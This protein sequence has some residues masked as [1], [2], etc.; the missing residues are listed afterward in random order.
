MDKCITNRL[1]FRSKS[2]SASEVVVGNLTRR[3][4]KLI[5]E[6]HAAARQEGKG[7]GAAQQQ[8]QQQQQGE[9]LQ[10]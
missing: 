6:D 2:A 9:S 3:A 8:Q 7:G 4:L 10:R 1:Y 5:R